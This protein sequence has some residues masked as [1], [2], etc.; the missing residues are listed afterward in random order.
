MS[1]NTNESSQEFKEESVSNL[2]WNIE[3]FDGTDFQHWLWEYI[4]GSKAESDMKDKDHDAAMAVILITSD[5]PIRARIRGIKKAS[6]YG[7]S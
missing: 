4:E 2:V 5:K 6:K 1:P 3:N 7:P